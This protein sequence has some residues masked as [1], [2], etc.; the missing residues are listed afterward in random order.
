MNEQPTRFED[1]LRLIDEA[2]LV[3]PNTESFEGEEYPKE[4]LYSM[5]MTRWLEAIEPQASE[6]L[7]LAVRSQHIRRWEIPRSEYPLGRKGYHQWRIRLYDYHGE[8]AAEILEKV[9]YDEQ[10][11]ARVRMLLKKQGLKTDTETQT[12]EDV[13]CLVFLE[14]YF[15][16]FSRLHDEEKII[17][18]LRKTW[19]KMSVR[20]QEAARELSLNAGAQ[21]LLN[22]ALTPEK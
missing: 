17:G 12:L 10:T 6:A 14:S 13:A 21:D 7:R 2:N 18:I 3:D 8:K 11:I 9:G 20:G 22:K 15:W 16:D 1:A 19:A 5:R 4:L